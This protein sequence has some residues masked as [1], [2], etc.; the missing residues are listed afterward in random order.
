M[1]SLGSNFLLDG[2]SLGI[3]IEKPFEILIKNKDLIRD[4]SN[5]V[6]PY[7]T[8]DKSTKNGDELSSNTILGD[9]FRSANIFIEV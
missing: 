9:L 7:E 5:G 8:T 1:R 2:T 3:T 4:E 6:E